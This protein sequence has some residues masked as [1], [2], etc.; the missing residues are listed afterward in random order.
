MIH[1]DFVRQNRMVQIEEK[2]YMKELNR[3]QEHLMDQEMEKNRKVE[4]D[5][6]FLREEARLQLAHDSRKVLD[7]QIEERARL[8]REEGLAEFEKDKKMV[9]DVIAKLKRDDAVAMQAR[10]KKQAETKTLIDKYM[11]Q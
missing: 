7:R 11:K 3:K 10:I 4:E 5:K 6:L 2:K 1:T 8:V 9:D